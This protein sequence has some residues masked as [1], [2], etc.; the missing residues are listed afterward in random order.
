[1]GYATRINKNPESIVYYE[2]DNILFVSNVNC[3][4]TEKDQNGFISKALFK[5][6]SSR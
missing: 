4:P 5:N 1:M 3:N 2:P 6:G